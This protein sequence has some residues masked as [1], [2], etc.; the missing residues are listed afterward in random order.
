MKNRHFIAILVLSLSTLTSISIAAEVEEWL[1]PCRL[2]VVNLN[3]AFIESQN[4]S[5]PDGTQHVSI[6]CCDEDPLAPFSCNHRLCWDG[7]P[8]PE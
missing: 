6:L 4:C 5:S 7:T 3:H 8:I 1:K 2:K